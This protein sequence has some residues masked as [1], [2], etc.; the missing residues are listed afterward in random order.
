MRKRGLAC[1]IAASMLLGACAAACLFAWWGRALISMQSTWPSVR[2][3]FS[4]ALMQGV[5][6]YTL[7][8]DGVVLGNMYGPAS[9]LYFAA[10]LLAPPVT[11]QILLGELLALLAIMTPL[12]IAV[13]LEGQRTRLDARAGVGLCIGAFALLLSRQ[14]TLLNLTHIHADAPCLGFGLASSLLIAQMRDFTWRRAIPSALLLALAVLSKQNAAFVAVA[15]GLILSARFGLTRAVAYG[16]LCAAF[17]AT[18]VAAFVALTPNTLDAMRFELLEIPA[19]QKIEWPRFA[20]IFESLLALVPLPAAVGV[21]GLLGPKL[22]RS[23]YTR[24]ALSRALE[25]AWVQLWLISIGLL[26]ISLIGRLKVGGFYNSYH[27]H[28]YAV[29]A[30]ALLL[31]H[32]FARGPLSKP[33]AQAAA[34]ALTV[35]LLLP[36]EHVNVS[37]AQDALVRNSHER[38]LAYLRSHP[39]AYFPWHPLEHLEA[40]GRVFHVADG[41]FSWQLSKMPL[42]YHHFQQGA[43]TS[44][45]IIAWPGRDRSI[46]EGYTRRALR[47]RYP[48]YRVAKAPRE[49]EDFVVLGRQPE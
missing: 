17:A 49:L 3:G 33:R 21:L 8:E 4:A 20:T 40:Q 26:P 37:T 45:Q 48:A 12:C 15:Q 25:P 11:W 30:L 38:V 2:L 16:L 6:I 1:T 5:P 22:P 36:W 29:A 34:L 9:A 41:L 28:A 43:P 14:G 35:G 32:W 24:A 42:S 18:S 13:G 19:A 47:A 27:A 39:D 44:P 23:A 10:A 7:P 31:A 46:L